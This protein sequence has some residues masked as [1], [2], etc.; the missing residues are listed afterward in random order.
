MQRKL[1]QLQREQKEKERED[2]ILE[3]EREKRY[4]ERLD[5]ERKQYER[6]IDAKYQP[7][8]ESLRSE[9]SQIKKEKELNA[10]SVSISS[11]SNLPQLENVMPQ[12][13]QLQ[14]QV[15]HMQQQQMQSQQQQMK[16][17]ERELKEMEKA[18]KKE[19]K[20]K[21]KERR[22]VAEMERDSYGTPDAPIQ[23]NKIKLMNSPNGGRIHK[24][25]GGKRVEEVSN[26]N[27]NKV[28]FFFLFFF[29]LF[30]LQWFLFVA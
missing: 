28:C 11:I 1:D 4:L 26:A 10:P 9:V 17:K 14:Q 20:Q 21:R 27:K 18:L 30:R 3:L 5:L 19:K 12:V 16:E 13:Q 15:Q 2:K 8:I 29:Y 6:Q 7:L 22:F 23:T 25:Y 24:N